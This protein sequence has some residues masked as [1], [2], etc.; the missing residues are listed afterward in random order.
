MHFL[1]L[2]V[3]LLATSSLSTV[4]NAIRLTRLSSFM[5]SSLPPDPRHLFGW[6][7]NPITTLPRNDALKVHRVQLLE[8]T[9]LALH[10]EEVDNQSAKEIASRKHVAVAEVDGRRD[11]GREEGKQEV[12][13]P[14]GGSRQRHALGAVARRVQLAADG[15][16]HGAP[17]GSEAEDEEARDDD[18]GRARRLG[19]LGCLPVEREVPA[20]SKD[21]EHEEHPHAANDEGGAATC[22]FDEVDADWCLGVC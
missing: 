15:P 8:R 21:E 3:R 4:S 17:G 2:L 14:V 12:P 16:D 18:H 20:R 6:W 13:Q 9:A 22:C 7:W 5:G 10:D 1:L 11:E 19:V